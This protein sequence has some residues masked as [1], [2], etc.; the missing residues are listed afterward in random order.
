RL[1]FTGTPAPEKVRFYTNQ[2]AK[3]T[4]GTDLQ[5]QGTLLAPLAEVSV[6]SNGIVKGALYAKL[7]TL[8]TV[9]KMTYQP[10]SGGTPLVKITSPANGFLT[11]QSAIAVAWTVDGVAQTT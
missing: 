11:N 3:V 9:V 10:L 1:E 8:A 6:S 4:L 5:F 7:L 2:T